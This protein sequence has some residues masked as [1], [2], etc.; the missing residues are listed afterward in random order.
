MLKTHPSRHQMKKMQ[1]HPQRQVIWSD[2]ALCHLLC[3]VGYQKTDLENVE[4][5]SEMF[6]EISSLLTCTKARLMKY[7]ALTSSSA[8]QMNQELVDDL[9]SPPVGQVEATKELQSLLIAK[10]P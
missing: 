10:P 8:N 6:D 3:L 4:G 1:I 2:L 9:P 5:N 7:T